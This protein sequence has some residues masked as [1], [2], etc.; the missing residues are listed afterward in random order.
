MLNTTTPSILEKIQNWPSAESKEWVE[1]FLEKGISSCG[2][3]AV[4]IY[5]SI[6][7]NVR[8]CADVDLL[9]IYSGKKPKIYPPMD[10]DVRMYEEGAVEGLIRDGNE[11]LGWAIQFGILLYEQNF[12]WNDISRRWKNHLPLPSPVEAEKRAERARLLLEDLEKIGDE[13]AIN[14]QLTTLLT[15]LGRANLIRSG[16]FPASRPE[17]PDQL[18]GIGKTKIANR[19]SKL[20]SMRK[21][22]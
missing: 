8:Y 21:V 4:V 12:Y 1:I 17:L 15:Q 7:R 5:G 3:S 10:V 9:I 20:L 13:D 19:L 16:I 22:T 2:I 14:E 6:V 18:R 11:V